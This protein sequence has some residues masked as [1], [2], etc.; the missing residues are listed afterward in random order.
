LYNRVVVEKSLNPGSVDHLIESYFP[1][2]R[3]PESPPMP[4][5][6]E[7]RRRV[8]MLWLQSRTQEPRAA[9][10]VLVARLRPLL[11]EL[12][13][14]THRE[15]GHRFVARFDLSCLVKQPES[16]LEKMVRQSERQNP[17]PILFDNLLREM[18]DIARFRIVVN[19][20]SD[21]DGIKECLESLADPNA[22][23]SE[24]ASALAR[25]FELVKNRFE[26]GFRMH[27]SERKK[28]ERCYK[29]VFR[30]K[31]PN[32]RFVELQIMTALGEAWDKKD[33]FLVYERR[34]R[35]ETVTVDEEI[36][37]FSLSEMLYI[38]DLA[39]ERIRQQRAAERRPRS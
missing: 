35:G 19:F 39:F 30:T 33:H 34:R 22:P 37:I 9:A 29:G 20:L 13:E 12:S 7:E 16:I 5:T 15:D 27:P 28:G 11:R 6:V 2:G 1:W 18:T 8:A 36:E 17:P 3:P 4:A 31:G 24:A 32:P 26:D 38:A 21:A 25:D 23:R 14:Q 10:L